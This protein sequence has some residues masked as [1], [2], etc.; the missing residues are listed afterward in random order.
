MEYREI[1]CM[2]G[3]GLIQEAQYDARGIYLCATCPKCEKEKLGHYR[4][5]VLTD[6]DYWHDEP[7]DE[8]E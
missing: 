8:D 6:P 3:S 4:P 1:E 7:L 2:C 5:D